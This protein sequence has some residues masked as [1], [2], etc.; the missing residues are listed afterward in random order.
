MTTTKKRRDFNW[1]DEAGDWFDY[2]HGVN[3]E[4]LFTALDHVDKR[5]DEILY[6]QNLYTFL[7]FGYWGR[8]IGRFL[9]SKIHSKCVDKD[10]LEKLKTWALFSNFYLWKKQKDE[11]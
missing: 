8:K 3:Q 7:G 11:I 9:W 5:I 6:P 1:R 4:R 10:D 2:Q